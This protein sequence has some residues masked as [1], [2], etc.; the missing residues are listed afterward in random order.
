MN[1]MT[2]EIHPESLIRLGNLELLA[3]AAVEGFI[4]GLHK[5]PFH[6][7]SVEFAEHR[8]YN[9]GESTRHIDWKLYART[10]KLFVKKYE[11]E[12]NLR[13]R[14]VIDRSAGMYFPFDS[15]ENKIR[16]SV[17]ASASLIELLRR[18]R[19]AMGITL[20]DDEIRFSSQ[21]KSGLI[22]IR[23]LYRELEK[24]LSP[25]TPGIGSGTST[26]EVLHQIAETIHRRSLVILFSDFFSDYSGGK[27]PDSELDRL[28]EAIRHLKHNKHEVI[29]FRVT[30]KKLETDFAFDNRPYLFIDPET[31]KEVRLNPTEI[32]EGYQKSIRRLETRIRLMCGQHGVDYNEADISEGLSRVMMSFMTKRQRML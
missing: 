12:T 32:R 16:F 15:A 14:I 27:T 2:P 30:D 29:V 7:F 24:L 23:G 3:K 4:T 5:S 21:V 28:M 13:C 31:G 25:T 22:H 9:T 11:E 10:E 17:F 19:D 1:D 8:Q 18:Q 20:Y 6:G 26:T